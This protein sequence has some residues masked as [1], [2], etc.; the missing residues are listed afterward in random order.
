MLADGLAAA[1]VPRGAVGLGV[2]LPAGPGRGAED[3]V[4]RG[5]V[6]LGVTAD[7]D[8]DVLLGRCVAGADGLADA[9]FVPA[10]GALAGS[11]TGVAGAAGSAG[12][13]L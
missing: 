2:P 13:A 1:D 11:A 3:G 6:G 7:L 12:A 4:A 5:A 8:V 9:G 10:L